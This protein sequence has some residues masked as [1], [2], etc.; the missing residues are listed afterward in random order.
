M[1][2]GYKKPKVKTRDA[3]LHERAAYLRP[4]GVGREM[5]S[6]RLREGEHSFEALGKAV[7]KWGIEGRDAEIVFKATNRLI[8]YVHDQKSDAFRD[9]LRILEGVLQQPRCRARP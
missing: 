6:E 4:K 2:G 5:W 9:N 7:K 8:E 1:K 3:T